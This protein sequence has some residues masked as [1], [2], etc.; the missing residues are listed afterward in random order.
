MSSVDALACSTPPRPMVPRKNPGSYQGQGA[1]SATPQARQPQ[2]YTPHRTVAVNPQMQVGR[3]YARAIA[4]ARPRSVITWGLPPPRPAARSPRPR[5]LPWRHPRTARK[6]PCPATGKERRA[7]RDVPGGRAGQDLAGLAGPVRA[8]AVADLAAHDRKMRNGH[9]GSGELEL[10]IT[11]RCRPVGL[12]LRR[13]D[14]TR[15]P[16]ARKDTSRVSSQQ[17]RAI[18]SNAG[19]G[20]RTTASRRGGAADARLEGAPAREHAGLVGDVSDCGDPGPVLL[21]RQHRLQRLP[22]FLAETAGGHEP[23]C[24]W[25]AA[26]R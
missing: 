24:R 4:V 11:S 23:L 3:F 20:S 18:G 25:N 10:L 1:D 13:D 6:S 17:R 2:P 5:N 22:G 21:S 14:G 15:T 19:P 26:N 12:T 9:G 7:L 8:G 16:R